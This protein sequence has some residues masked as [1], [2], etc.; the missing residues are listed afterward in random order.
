VVGSA[1]L[2]LGPNTGVVRALI[3]ADRSFSKLPIN[4]GLFMLVKGNDGRTAT[5]SLQDAASI[6][7][8][9]KNGVAIFV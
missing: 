2:K 8:E 5:A 9:N 7:N 1:Q 6:W 4:I 3:T